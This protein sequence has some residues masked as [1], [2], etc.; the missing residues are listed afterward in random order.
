MLKEKDLLVPQEFVQ[1][2]PQDYIVR[3]PINPFCGVKHRNV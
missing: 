1:V 2:A 3:S